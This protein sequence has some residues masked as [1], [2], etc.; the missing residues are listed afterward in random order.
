[1][2]K[3]KRKTIVQLKEKKGKAKTIAVEREQQ[4]M[5]LSSRSVRA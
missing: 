4:V 2:T 3:V 5:L 1:M